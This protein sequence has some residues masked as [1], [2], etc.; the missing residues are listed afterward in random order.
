MSDNSI[1]QWESFQWYRPLD[2]CEVELEPGTPPDPDAKNLIAA[3]GRPAREFIKRKSDRMQSYY[4][5]QDEP[6]LFKELA[7]IDDTSEAIADFVSRYG[8]LGDRWNQEPENITAESVSEFLKVKTAVFAALTLHENGRSDLAALTIN[9][10]RPVV[11]EVIDTTNPKRMVPASMPVT[12]EG[13][14]WLQVRDYVCLGRTLKHCLWESCIKSFYIG[15]GTGTK[16][17]VFCSP[18]CKMAFTRK[19]GSYTKWKETH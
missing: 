4:P 8:F 19:H 18:K 12:L 5:H 3:Q 17:K 9:D 11:F 6:T 7:N 13:L 16:A 2:G 10:I 14:I 15:K 1:T